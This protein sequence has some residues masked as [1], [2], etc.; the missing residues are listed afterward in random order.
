MFSQLK[1]RTA[2]AAQTATL[3]LASLG[4]GAAWT[5]SALTAGILIAPAPAVAAASDEKNDTVIF[6]SGQTVKGEILEETPTTIRMRV[7]VAGIRAE[8]TYNKSDIL[9]ITR[10]TGAGADAKPAEGRPAARPGST[11]APATAAASPGDPNRKRVYVLELT[12]L[13]GKDITQTP[14]R[15]AIRDARNNNADYIIVNL[16]N[17]WSVNHG[18]ELAEDRPD[19]QGAFDMLFRAL[20]IEPIFREEIPREWDNPPKIVFWVRNAMG[21]AAFLPLSCRDIYFHS[22]GR[23]GGIGFMDTMFDGVGDEEVRQK[24]YSLRITRAEG[25]AIAG[26]YDPRIVRAMALL[27]YVLSVRFVG[28]QPEFFEGV[29]TRDGDIQL[30]NNGRIQEQRDTIQMLARGEGKNV[31]TL[32]ADLAMKLGVSK[33]TADTLQDLMFHLGIARNHEVVS[34]QSERI[35]KQWRDSVAAAERNLRRS[36]HTDYRE[37]RVEGDVRQRNA[38]RSRQIR[39]IDEMQSLLRRYEEAINPRALQIPDFDTLNIL[40]EQI[41]L[42]ILADRR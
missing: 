27:D 35:M 12:G 15:D 30:T 1:N 8:T 41:R 37:I 7:E 36:W 5:G 28:G 33:G 20:D 19:D 13:F 23:M 34:G 31:L 14:V 40:K 16:N 38:A 10:G 39:I 24:Q 9:S 29:P 11:P 42:Q 18:T 2:R 17:D 32:R 6:R 3:L 4:L 22:Q 21:G 25:L 26:G